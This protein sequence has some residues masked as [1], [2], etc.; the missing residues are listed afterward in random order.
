MAVSL[1]YWSLLLTIISS[2]TDLPRCAALAGAINGARHPFVTKVAV[3]GATG[4]TGRYIV[5]E[6]L[7]RKIPVVA[8]VR[9]E[10]KAQEIFDSSETLLDIISCD[11]SQREQVEAGALPSCS[12]LYVFKRI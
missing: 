2:L 7:D 6:L 8:L 3:T 4:R 10:T 9:N 12:L 5:Q 1:T 11:L